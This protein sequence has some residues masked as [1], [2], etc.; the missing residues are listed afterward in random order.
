MLW[1]KLGP[2]SIVDIVKKTPVDLLFDPYKVDLVLRDVEF[3]G[4]Q[5]EGLFKAGTNVPHGIGR[6]VVFDHR[7]KL[8]EGMFIE[9]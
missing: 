2:I 7:D 5:V 4:A 3:E 1:D 8:Y 6:Q 9:G